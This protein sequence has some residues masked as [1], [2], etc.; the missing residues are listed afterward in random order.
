MVI[1]ILIFIRY[2]AVLFWCFLTISCAFSAEQRLVD[3]K[4]DLANHFNDGR[5]PERA[6]LINVTRSPRNLV[7]TPL[8]SHDEFQCLLEILYPAISGS[9]FP[10]DEYIEDVALSNAPK[11]VVS[12][13][14]KLAVFRSLLKLFDYFCDRE[15]HDFSK[16][17]IFNEMFFSQEQALNYKQ[18]CFLLRHLKNLS[19]LSPNS[20]IFSNFL[21]T[22]RSRRRDYLLS[23]ERF[24]KMR[25][26]THLGIMAFSGGDVLGE[27]EYNFYHKLYSNRRIDFLSNK[28]IAINNGR[29]IMSYCKGSY[30]Q[31]DDDAIRDGAVYVFGN[32][33]W[34][35]PDIQDVLI[36]NKQSCIYRNI[37]I[38]VCF[39]LDREIGNFDFIL[40]R[41]RYVSSRLHIIQANSIDPFVT[42]I[43]KLPLN[44]GIVHVDSF[45]HPYW[46]EKDRRGQVPQ[47]LY[48]PFLDG[49]RSILDLS[50]EK[51]SFSIRIGDSDYIISFLII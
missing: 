19:R 31:E 3:L 8:I 47:N 29:S 42:N 15:L 28:T 50:Y 5:F 46:I 36:T 26:K 1:T 2:F 44:R 13:D 48:L 51:N 17:V 40:N 41:G 16:I 32:G 12:Y 38:Q 39:D 20:I 22:F 35:S 43:Q 7:K 23:I 11:A 33:D 6:V 27:C 21:Y 25:L 18:F 4:Q 34:V 49:R 24:Y 14:N 30:F 37:S 45:P 9:F 10:R